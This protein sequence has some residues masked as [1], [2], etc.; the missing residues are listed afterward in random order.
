MVCKRQNICGDLPEKTAFKSYAA[1]HEQTSQ[2]ANY[3]LTCRQLFLLNAQRSTRGYPTSIKDIQPCPKIC[4]L[5]LLARVGARS[6]STTRTATMGGV[7]NFPL[8]HIG[9]ARAEGLHFSAFHVYY[10]DSM[11]AQ[12]QWIS[13][14]FA[15]KFFSVPL[16]LA[17][18]VSTCI[19]E[20]SCTM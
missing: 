5:M 9:I 15:V 18:R 3:R 16:F 19:T 2:Y 4:L 6:D 17:A 10:N 8:T 12:L 11:H 20:V 13:N 7:A 14:V 1:K